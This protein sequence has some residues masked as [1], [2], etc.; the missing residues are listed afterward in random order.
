MNAVA[1]H[2]AKPKIYHIFM[3]SFGLFGTAFASIQAKSNTRTLLRKSI[4]LNLCLLGTNQ[5]LGSNIAA[6]I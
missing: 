2:K 1:W 6:T 4:N 3:T 5:Q